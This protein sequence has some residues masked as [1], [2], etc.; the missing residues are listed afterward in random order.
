MFLPG[1]NPEGWVWC[2]FTGKLNSMQT[3]IQ[4]YEI[5]Q[6]PHHTHGHTDTD[7]DTS[8]H[9]FPLFQKHLPPICWS[10]SQ[11]LGGRCTPDRQSAQ[12]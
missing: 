6:L 1:K 9:I 2:V 5:T 11:P 10:W 8:P 4:R 3:G 7:T 12:T